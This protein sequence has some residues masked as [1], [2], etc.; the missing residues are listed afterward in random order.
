MGMG[1]KHTIR[2]YGYLLSS[3]RDESDLLQSDCTIFVIK[4]RKSDIF[5]SKW[6]L[7]QIVKSWLEVL[8][9][10]EKFSDNLTLNILALFKNLVHVQIAQVKTALD[11]YYNTLGTRV[12][13]R[14]AER[15]KT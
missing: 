15:V 7:F 8:R 10:K 9:A 12:A 6:V 5:E 1:M 13:S 3:M 2:L 11:T 14:V 4:R